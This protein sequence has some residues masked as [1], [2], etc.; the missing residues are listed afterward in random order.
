MS[1]YT[2]KCIHT[3]VKFNKERNFPC[4]KQNIKIK[5]LAWEY[6]THFSSH[7]PEP[8]SRVCL[9]FKLLFL[10][11]QNSQ[12]H[13]LLANIFSLKIHFVKW[14]TSYITGSLE[15]ELRP[16]IV[17]QYFK[18]LIFLYDLCLQLKGRDSDKSIMSF[19][20]HASFSH[21]LNITKN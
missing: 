1:Q 6:T 4:W 2:N 7:F 9:K 19:L 12:K 14:G 21:V 13:N 17:Y 8:K 11:V 15:F 20:L 18:D 5:N 3:L 16:N 10:T